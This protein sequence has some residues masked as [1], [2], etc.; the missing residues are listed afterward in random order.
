MSGVQPDP[1]EVRTL[2]EARLGRQPQD[3]IE[4]AV[5][6]EAWAGVPA[7]SAL[8]AGAALMRT[9]PPQSRAS[10]GRLPKP[11]TQE[12]FLVEAM[13]FVM[14]VI[15]IAC[16]AVPLASSVGTEAIESAV[17]FALP[18]TLAL[19]WGLQSRY[20]GHPQGLA[21][22]GRRWPVLVLGAC[23]LVA[24]PTALLGISGTVAGLLTVTWTGGAILIRRRWAASYAM[25][26]VLATAAMI[27]G[28]PAVAVLG[29]TA[30][31]TTLAV[32]VAVA[33]SSG[34]SPA[35]HA[36]RRWGRALHA[37]VIGTG[38]GLMLVVDNS[39]SWSEG[40]VPALAL[41]PSTVASLWGGY[42]L[43][44]LDQVILRAVSGVAVSDTHP[45][46]LAWQPLR[47]LL[48]AIG[49]VVCLTAALSAALVLLA[50]SLG[51]TSHSIGILTGFGLLALAM[52]LVSLLESAGQGRWTLVAVGYGVAVAEL[53]RLDGTVPFPG[54][55]LV[56]AAAL[57]VLVSLPAAI[58]LLSRPAGTLATALWIT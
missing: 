35:G 31:A 58:A 21:E 50:S 33:L 10:V 38:L 20:L 57:A 27:A 14:T 13:A 12:G 54:A 34:S 51:S 52:L 40:M 16:W 11:G 30:G 32:A 23:G 45:R 43:R 7:Q 1:R 28:L 42:H 6:L 4:A 5:V 24:M 37:S 39:M 41:V 17:T 3:M 22:L 26:V 19:Q 2:I 29:A 25:T 36:P 47:V 9:L 44:R 53:M 46:G 55:G 15:A 18:L 56:V 48:G 49:R 8:E